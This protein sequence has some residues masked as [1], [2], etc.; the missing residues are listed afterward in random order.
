MLTLF[1]RFESK[2]EKIPLGGCWVWMAGLDRDGYG[3]LGQGK[4]RKHKSHRLSYQLYKGT[5]PQKSSV[6]HTC[7]NPSCA[8]PEHL[9]LGTPQDNMADK[10]NKGRS[11]KGE[12][13]GSSKLTEKDV[14]EILKSNQS[15]STLGKLYG[16]S[17]AQIHRIKTRKAWSHLE[18]S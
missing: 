8:N 9:F 6:L 10:C 18:V 2:I 3:Q 14:T 1:E 13:Q 11:A 12:Q 7:D 17:Q 5:I 4:Y 16:V 15:Q